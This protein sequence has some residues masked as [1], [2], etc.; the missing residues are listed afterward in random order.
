[1]KVADKARVSVELRKLPRAHGADRLTPI[2]WRHSFR[3]L[4]TAYRHDSFPARATFKENPPH[5]KE[6]S[7]WQISRKPAKSPTIKSA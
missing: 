2:V 1:M 4:M 6:R 7:L 5:N 3:H